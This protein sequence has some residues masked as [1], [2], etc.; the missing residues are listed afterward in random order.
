ME[1]F[2]YQREDE[3]FKKPVQMKGDEEVMIGNYDSAPDLYGELFSVGIR[4]SIE[5]VIYCKTRKILDGIY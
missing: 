2:A 1:Q 4:T 3:K 5:T